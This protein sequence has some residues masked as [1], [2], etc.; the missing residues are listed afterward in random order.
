MTVSSVFHTQHYNLKIILNS[1][2]KCTLP[3]IT[4]FTSVIH[5]WRN[6]KDR[7]ERIAEMCLGDPLTFFK[8]FWLVQEKGW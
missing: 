2:F 4:F 5:Y 6:P 3:F 8:E 7:A 1:T